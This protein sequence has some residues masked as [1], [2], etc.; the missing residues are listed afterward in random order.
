MRTILFLPILVAFLSGCKTVSHYV[1]RTPDTGRE[2][3]TNHYRYGG[4]GK[5]AFKDFNGHWVVL[6]EYEI[7]TVFN[8][9]D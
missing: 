9:T 6:D 1:I 7:E 8:E 4:G 2:Y 3:Q 5:I